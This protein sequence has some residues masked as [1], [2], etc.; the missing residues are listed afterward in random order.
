MEASALVDAVKLIDVALR[1][2][3][4]RELVGVDYLRDL[5]LDVRLLI[6]TEAETH[7]ISDRVP[8]APG[9]EHSTSDLLRRFLSKPP[10]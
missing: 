3:S 2:T 10:S 6:A 7:G 8:P 9:P 1:E 4:G 5:L